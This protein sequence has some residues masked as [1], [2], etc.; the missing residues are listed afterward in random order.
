[1][2]YPDL[3]DL[4]FFAV[5]VEHG[6]YA[7]AERALGIPK[8]RLSRRITQLETDLGVRLLQRSTRKFS[9]T[10]VGQNVYRHAQSMLAEAQAAREVVD[11]VS[12][13]PRGIIKVSAPVLLAEDILSKLIPE[14]M[15]QFPKVKVQLHVSN[16]R[17]DVINEGFDIALRVRNSL[18]TDADFILKRFGNFHELLVASPEYLKRNGMPQHPQELGTHTTLSMNEDEARQ[19]WELH[20]DGNGAVEK[21]E[22]NPSLMA[23]SFS[24]LHEAALRGIGIA[25]L[26]QIIC[27][28]DLKSGRLQK[29]LP[30]WSLPL[31]ICHAVF[32]SRRG[33]LP[34]V[35]VFI[36][37]LAEQLPK[38]I[39]S[40]DV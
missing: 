15:L 17:V 23:L 12:A 37:F 6:G 35:R 13:E 38:K 36:D 14:F 22:I 11:R 1:M 39:K 20:H 10:D 16:R 5:V 31:G 24:L 32:P 21:V 28:E 18:A 4:Q 3:N 34:A 8:S 7:A 19:R 33:L 25:L 26:P 2:K 9:V 40:C 27:S 29:V 30:E